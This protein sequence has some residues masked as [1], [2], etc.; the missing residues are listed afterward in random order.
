MRKGLKRFSEACES[1]KTF[2]AE[3][4]SNQRFRRGFTPGRSS[5]RVL[6]VLSASAVRVG[7]TQV[8][9]AISDL[10]INPLCIV[11]AT[12]IACG[13]LA[14]AI[15]QRPIRPARHKRLKAYPALKPLF[16]AFR[17]AQTIGTSVAIDLGESRA[18]EVE[19]SGARQKEL[20]E[21]IIR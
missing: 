2:T 18:T 6:W 14:G 13:D 16:P 12:S 15:G 8:Q 20:D 10:K 4:R 9:A 11:I 21:A 3:T 1:R 7:R 19:S 5:L 17:V